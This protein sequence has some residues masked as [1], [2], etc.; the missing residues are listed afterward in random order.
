MGKTTI[1]LSTILFC[2]LFTFI[3]QV[4]AQEQPAPSK[5]LQELVEKDGNIGVVAG[6]SVDGEVKWLDA[7]GYSCQNTQ[8]PFSDSTITRIA[9]ISKSMTAV[10]VMQLVEKNLIELDEPIQVYL[11]NFPKNKM[12]DI[13]T[14][15]LLAHTSGI[16]QYMNKKE[17]ENTLHYSNLSE[18][19]AVFQDRPL[20][21][22]PGTQYYYTSYGY[23]VL[24]RIIEEASG[25]SFEEYMQHNIW[26][27][28]EMMQTGI[29]QMD[30]S[31]SNKACLYHKEKKKAKEA[32]QNDL[33]NRI[34]GGGFYSTAKDL[35]KFGDALLNEK[36]ITKQSL[37]LMLQKQNVEY[38]GNSYGLGWYFYAPKPNENLVIGHGGGQTGCTSQLMII[39]HSKTVVIVLSYTSGTYP[40]IVGMASKLI[41]ESEIQN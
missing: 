3:F 15:Q 40:S 16:S 4:K 25:L 1:P 34:P 24:G 18:A 39:P 20:L 31:Y 33:S 28:A 12:G 30:S 36:L 27:K 41:A 13:T 29:E 9:S 14:R 19:I 10:A 32:K 23:V 5:S 7:A 22:K 35:L 6:Y 17:V 37:G 26:D 11:P 2:V 21:F 8:F 38:E